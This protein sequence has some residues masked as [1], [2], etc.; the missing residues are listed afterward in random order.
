M[1][2]SVE[3]RQ[4]IPPLRFHALTPAY[5]ALVRWTCAEVRFRESLT[6]ALATRP[7]SSVVDIG[8]GTGSLLTMLCQRFPDAEIVGIDADEAAL[9]VAQK[10]LSAKGY[11]ASLR[12]ADGRDLPF[13]DGSVEAF[14][15][16]LFFHHLEDDSKVEVLREVRRCLSPGG[17]LVVADWDRAGSIFRRAAF[18]A[19]RGLDGFDVTRLHAEGRF[20]ELIA[21][22]GFTLR[23]AAPIPA[24][25][26]QIGVWTFER[27]V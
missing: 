19:V 24:P 20:P 7:F 13:P 10:K 8:C 6:S 16:S 23:A 14:T 22:S 3:T 1:S 5:D 15:S 2:E 4:Y 25:L 26:G 9:R 21:R 17:T 11:D 27:M 12:M 18:H